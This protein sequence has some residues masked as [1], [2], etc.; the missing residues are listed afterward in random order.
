MSEYMLTL[1]WRVA[2]KR[3]IALE[4]FCHPPHKGVIEELRVITPPIVRMGHR[5]R[6]GMREPGRPLVA[7][8]TPVVSRQLVRRVTELADVAFR[9][10]SSHLDD[11][12]TLPLDEIAEDV[13]TIV[14]ER[15]PE[16]T[17]LVLE[18][19]PEDESLISFEIDHGSPI[20]LAGGR[21]D[22]T[23]PERTVTKDAHGRIE[24][25]TYP[26]RN[27]PPAVIGWNG[28]LVARLPGVPVAGPLSGWTDPEA[29]VRAGI[30]KIVVT[31]LRQLDSAV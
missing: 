25:V 29:M 28:K 24:R 13:C 9:A 17:R 12:F 16:L 26:V 2:S 11:M 20:V 10:A 30:G 3:V 23:P 4:P 6:W 15:L 5:V 21:V 7:L 22:P 14:R 31:A 1:G 8:D 18:S 27:L 19:P